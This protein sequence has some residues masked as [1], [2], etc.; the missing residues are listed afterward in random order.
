MA[1]NGED[2]IGRGLFTA[3]KQRDLEKFLRQYLPICGHVI[4]RNPEWVHKRVFFFDITAG[5]G[6][7][8]ETGEEGSPLILL[9][10]AE[11]LG[12][13]YSAHFIEQQ[14]DNFAALQTIVA[15]RGFR[16]GAER[17]FTCGDH[18]AALPPILRH[19]LPLRPQ[20]IGL[21]YY[22]FTTEDFARS[23]RFIS[24]VYQHFTNRMERI[25]CLLYLSATAV[26]RVRG[27]FPNRP[28]LM[29]YLRAIQKKRWLIREPV[30]ANHYT[31]LLGT[32]FVDYKTS[33]P[34]GLF[35]IT[36]RRGFDILRR[37]NFNS[38]ELKQG[39]P[40]DLFRPYRT[41]EEYL[42][43]PMFLFVR[44]IVLLRARGR[45]EQCRISPVS[46]VHHLKYPPWGTFDEP[47][48][49]I[50]ICHACHCE[51]HEKES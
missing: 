47:E 38:D 44:D 2:A 10:L 15:A 26:K 14:P 16:H 46:E 11:E 49:L 30:G 48:N 18:V 9:R 12:I 28:D 45:C 34:I 20:P 41:Y 1:R 23:L 42:K 32:N 4:R 35:P 24:E 6:I 27:A 7:H 29:T 19:Y 8:P 37:V 13:D 51:I 22:D 3:M 5:K 39:E 40:S 33:I 43:H 21:L 17:T 31:F 25:D 36:E 50:A